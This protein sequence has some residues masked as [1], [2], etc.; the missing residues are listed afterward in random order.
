VLEGMWSHIQDDR[1]LEQCVGGPVELWTLIRKVVVAG[2]GMTGQNPPG[3]RGHPA[4]GA[5]PIDRG[6]GGRALGAP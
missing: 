3:P 6:L 4:S 1:V 2:V 5:P